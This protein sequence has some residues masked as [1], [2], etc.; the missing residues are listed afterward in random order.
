MV[1]N[2]DGGLNRRVINLTLTPVQDEYLASKVEE[3]KYLSKQDAIRDL[4]D[5][6]MEAASA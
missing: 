4:I 1:S 6:T 3:G 2:G 5:K